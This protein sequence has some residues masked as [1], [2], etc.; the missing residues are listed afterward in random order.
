VA[1][2][3]GPV[4]KGGICNIVG[5]FVA[6]PSGVPEGIGSASLAGLTPILG[7]YSGE[8]ARRPRADRSAG[9]ARSGKRPAVRSSHR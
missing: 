4:A 1:K 7:I 2:G 8:G 6:G 5:G 3:D 9:A